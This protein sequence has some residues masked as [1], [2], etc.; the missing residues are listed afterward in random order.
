LSAVSFSAG[1][2]FLFAHVD[3]AFAEFLVNLF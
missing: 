3:Q 1:L 2:F